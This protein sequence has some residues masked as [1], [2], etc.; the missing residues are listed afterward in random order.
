MDS[1][2]AEFIGKNAKGI[3]DDKQLVDSIAK[4]IWNA[5][6]EAYSRFQSKDNVA[7]K[8]GR[9]TLESMLKGDGGFCFEKNLALKHVLDSLGFPATIIFATAF[10]EEEKKTKPKA[11]IDYI[12]KLPHH[13]ST[14]VLIKGDY[15][16][17]D[18]AGG[19]I[20]YLFLNPEETK[21]VRA[22]EKEVVFQSTNRIR[23]LRYA[24]KD[25]SERVCSLMQSANKDVIKT[26]CRKYPVYMTA[27]VHID[28][29]FSG[30]DVYHGNVLAET[31]ANID[32]LRADNL[33]RIKPLVRDK[34]KRI[35]N[36]FSTRCKILDM[37]GILY[38]DRK[39]RYKE[40][41]VQ[42]V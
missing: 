28:A 35:M 10:S 26:I 33:E 17:I 2:T 19:S 8:T 23:H 21:K 41:R 30:N 38:F 31:R 24:A 20:G 4:A 14:L 36:S 40:T 7:I 11:D 16:L 34:L 15:H 39:K 37:P 18:A 12:V 3:G 9:E 22:K 13:F 29:S 1:I 5:P 25:V 42:D 32:L 6:W 27:D